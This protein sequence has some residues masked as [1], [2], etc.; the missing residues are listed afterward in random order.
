MAHAEQ[1]KK[2]PTSMLSEFCAQQKAEP[3]C[4]ETVTSG[5]NPSVPIFSISAHALGFT[6]IGVG[7]SKIEAKHAASQNLIGEGTKS[8]YVQTCISFALN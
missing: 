3:P 8:I 5:T 4:Y 6:T 1:S 7:Q 2:T